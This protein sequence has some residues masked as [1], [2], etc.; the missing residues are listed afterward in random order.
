[1]KIRVLLPRIPALDRMLFEAVARSRTPGL[2]WLMPRFTRLGDN[3]RLW[4]VVSASLATVGGRRSKRAALR[5][6]GS[7]AMTSLLVNQGVKR[8]VRRPRPSLR[9]VPAVRRLPVQPLTTSFPSGHAAS[10]AA[11]TVGVGTEL[12]Q[13]APAVACLA[14]G[15]AYSRVYV[16]VHYPFDALV[17]AAIGTGIA[18]ATRRVWPAEPHVARRVQH[19]GE[20]RALEPNADGDGLALLVNPEAGA[21]NRVAVVDAV[22]E[23]L[24]RASVIEIGAG[25]D[26]EQVAAHAAQSA[27]AL[28]V[29]GGDGSALQVAQAAL[30]ARKPLLVLP[31]GTLNHLARDLGIESADDALAAFARGQAIAVD[32]ATI[33]GRP[34]LNSASFGAAPRIVDVRERLS[35]K[36]GRWPSQLLATLRV[37]RDAEP[38]VLAIGPEQRTVWTAFIG[39]CRHEPRGFAPSWRP[40]LDDGVLDIRLIEGTGRWLRLRVLLSALTGRLERSRAYRRWESPVVEVSSAERALRLS[41]DGE[42]FDGAPRFRAEKLPQRLTVFTPAR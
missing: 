40:R 23:R 3:S 15:I 30:A 11:F 1:M 18:L 19:G 26:L 38:L 21:D 14:T 42:V 2:D 5:G 16:G 28:G 24:P 32:V 29:L 13:A 20:R 8:V 36:L 12:P 17:G 22:R 31:G 6:V 37:V 34:F 10:A 27:T 4:M 33:D 7:I 25:E 35:G 39:N 41:R 9:H